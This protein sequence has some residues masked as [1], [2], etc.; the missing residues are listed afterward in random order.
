MARLIAIDWDQNS[1]YVVAG[2]TRGTAVKVQSALTWQEEAPPSLA[3]AEAI[4]QRLKQKLKEAGIAPAPLLGCVGRDRL[5]VKDIRFPPVSELEE[6]AVV[7]FQTVKELTDAPDDVVIDYV[8]RLS[9]S[10]T[11]RRAASVV[12]QKKLLEVY[13]KIA[14][15]AGLKLT[16]LTPRLMGAAMCLRRVIGTTVVTPPPEPA[17][18]TIA[19]VVL[20][21]KT[22]ELGVL[23]GPDFLLARSLH[24]GPNLFGEIRRNLALHEG[25][26]PDHL[27]VA[28][29]LTGKG[30]G[31]LRDRLGEVLEIPI[32]TFDPFAGGEAGSRAAG[33][34]G[35][36]AGPMGLL[37]HKAVGELP[38]NWVSPR[39][40]KPPPDP[41]FKRMRVWLL[42]G[43]LLLVGLFVGGQIMVAEEQAALDRVR[44]ETSD[45]E[46]KLKKASEQAKRLKAMS[47]WSNP[48]W[49]DEIYDLA[50]R[51]DLDKVRIDYL[52]VS[53]RGRVNE[54]AA[55]RYVGQITLRGRL[56]ASTTNAR[57]ADYD[58]M[59]STFTREGNYTIEPGSS[60]FDDTAFV[61]VLDVAR[62]APNEYTL[63]L[64]DPTLVKDRT[65]RSGSRTKENTSKTKPKAPS[66]KLIKTEPQEGPERSRATQPDETQL[67]ETQPGEKE[68]NNELP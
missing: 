14:T 62:R 61:L 39:E 18:G 40:P 38:I 10:Q 56:L 66:E 21:E 54:K 9:T 34:R 27:I 64:D 7:R 41:L 13:Q 59:V 24:A 25:Q 16:G 47:D 57:R 30:A 37:Y 32:H 65:S 58:K 22:A 44:S 33:N 48:T 42:I 5:I 11:E 46:E 8:P 15:A 50:G 20:G 60:K 19:L 45:T 6:P 26:S 4:G 23:Q 53:S 52:G 55:T 35:F 51:L 36:F 67:D 12:V 1:L 28:V 29:Y 17:T 68:S 3:N 2:E 31:E 63:Q 49:V 43:F